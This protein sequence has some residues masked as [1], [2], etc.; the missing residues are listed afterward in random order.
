MNFK[1][2]ID[3]VPLPNGKLAT[4]RLYSKKNEANANILIEKTSQLVGKLTLSDR[5]WVYVNKIKQPVCSSCDNYV[6]MLNPEHT[7]FKPSCS[8]KCSNALSHKRKMERL[9]DESEARKVSLERY[10]EMA[11]SNGKLSSNFSV[12]LTMKKY[13]VFDEFNNWKSNFNIDATNRIYLHL[14]KL[15]LSQIPKCKYC[16][17]ER[18][19]KEKGTLKNFI[20]PHCGLPACIKL[21]NTEHLKKSNLEK[22]GVESKRD[23]PENIEQRLD[24]ERRRTEEQRK[25]SIEYFHNLRV[26]SFGAANTIILENKNSLIELFE[27]YKNPQTVAAIMG[28]TRESLSAYAKKYDIHKIYYNKN[29]QTSAVED[30]MFAYV[31]TID[32]DTEQ[33]NRGTIGKKELDIYSKKH[34]IAIEVDGVYWH[35]ELR[36][37]NRYS[38]VEKTNM[39]EKLGIRLFH[40]FDCELKRHKNIWK[41]VINKAF[42]YEIT[43]IPASTTIVK[44]ISQSK[45]NKFLTKNDIAGKAQS[46]IN[47]ALEANEEILAVVSFCLSAKNKNYKWELLR[48]SNKI[49][50]IVVDGNRMLIDRFRKDYPGS[51]VVYENL[52]WA[53]DDKFLRL[54][55]SKI[56]NT[57][58]Q[59]LFTKSGYKLST[60]DDMLIRGIPKLCENFNESETE[61]ENLLSNGYYRIY[62]CGNTIFELR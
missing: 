8:Q 52:R 55:F 50:S 33:S 61:E 23:R 34:E 38:H 39:C 10:V 45:A 13:G 11:Y 58:P 28:M 44:P 51:I 17:R 37:N 21:Y 26:K 60:F 27:Q 25:K 19:T 36:N 31:K 49:G 56:G 62:D 7:K 24:T 54:G 14:Y 12:D 18:A 1:E 2:W 57:Q 48:L 9:K 20:L 32:P 35:G 29:H 41:D 3:Y 5:Y 43:K 42:D 47:Y 40:I 22:Y 6:V 16:D 53:D 30:C 15:G 59:E 46:S 4:L